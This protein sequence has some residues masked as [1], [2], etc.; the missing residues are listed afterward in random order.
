VVREVATTEYFDPNRNSF[1]QSH[2]PK[3]HYIKREMLIDDGDGPV[4]V[5]PRA[6]NAQ[7]TPVREV[8]SPIGGVLNHQGR[9]YVNPWNQEEEI[10]TDNQTVI[11]ILMNFGLA[12]LLVT[13]VNNNSATA[14]CAITLKQWIVVFALILA[15]NSLLTIYGID[16]QKKSLFQRKVHQVLKILCYT[17]TVG[18]LLRGVD[19]YSIDGIT[20]RQQAPWLCF[21][22]L[23][24]LL[25]GAI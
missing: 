7:L 8:E 23:A 11:Y 2:P 4:V 6:R 20:C 18:W 13:A 24:T 1:D 3:K 19:L 10:M 14:T 21:T 22:M 17:A 16:I 5:V 9:S 15:T 12:F 25:I